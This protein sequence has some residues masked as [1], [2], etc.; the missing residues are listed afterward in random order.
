[1]NV[2]HVRKLFSVFFLCCFIFLFTSISVSASTITYSDNLLAGYYVNSTVSTRLGNVATHYLEQAKTI[3][4][5]VHY[6]QQVNVLLQPCNSN[7]KLITW[8]VKNTDGSGFVRKTIGQIAQDYEK[9]HPGWKVL[10]GINAD[11]YYF[12][13]GERGHENGSDYFMPQPYGPF[14]ADGEKWFSISA[15]PYGGN[16]TYIAG[17][18]NDGSQDQIIQGFTN[19]NN[20]STSKVKIAGLYLSI[21]DEDN[22]VLSKHLID[23]INETPLE[24]ENALYSAYVNNVLGEIPSMSVTGN[25]LFVVQDAEQAYM[26][27]SKTYT[28]KALYD[29]KLLENAQNAFFGKG[30]ISALSSSVSIGKGQFAISVNN[31]ELLSEL[32]VGKR[33]IVQF[34][35]E[36]PMNDVES[37]TAYHTV[38]RSNNKDVESTNSYNT[39]SYPRSVFGRTASGTMVLVTVDGKQPVIGMNGTNQN[40]TNALLKH[41]GVV[42]AYQ[43]DGG[44]SV[45][46]VIRDGSNFKVVNSPADGSTRSVLTGMFFVT[47]DVQVEG[48]QIAATETSVSIN[49][50]ITKT[51]ERTISNVFVS[52]NGTQYPTSAGNVTIEGLEAGKSYE[53]DIYVEDENGISKTDFGGIVQTQLLL[54]IFLNCDFTTIENKTQFHPQFINGDAILEVVLIVNDVEYDLLDVETFIENFS[55]NQTI[56]LRYSAKLSEF[57]TITKE[58]VF[59]LYQS[60][61]MLNDVILT[62]DDFLIKIYN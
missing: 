57:V 46:M 21:M 47:R 43:M 59:P 58:V 27:N 22:N 4:N 9:N 32:A 17:I 50:K 54:P 41:Y 1:M 8:A 14:I 40:E 13:L 53:Y 33:I 35:Y 3:R 62:I 39:Q 51:F 19:W 37:A 55:E 48:K 18:L 26:S 61:V 60:T 25:H 52:L 31:P 7:S 56:S 45:T 23:K 34:E 44:G 42:E 30:T 29:Q 10:G 6:S 24:G 15:K 5:D 49:T 2:Y 16:G 28:Y 12:A 38:M 20:T 36:G 11:Q